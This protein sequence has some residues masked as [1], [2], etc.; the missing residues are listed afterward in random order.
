M[1]FDGQSPVELSWHQILLQNYVTTTAYMNFRSSFNCNQGHLFDVKFDK[2]SMG[3]SI[4]Q[5]IAL[6]TIIYSFK[7]TLVNFETVL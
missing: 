1:L 2:A 3:K 6:L 4:R 5:F 7:I